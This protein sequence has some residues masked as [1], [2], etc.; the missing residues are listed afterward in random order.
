M[1]TRA[2][3]VVIGDR[4]RRRQRPRRVLPLAL[5]AVLV[6]V[7][8][9]GCTAQAFRELSGGRYAEQVIGDAL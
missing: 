3:P 2:S 1:G 4:N 6:T 7:S 5:G 9:A 8:V